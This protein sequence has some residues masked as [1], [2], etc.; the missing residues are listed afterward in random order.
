MPIIFAIIPTF[1]Y[2]F[3]CAFEGVSGFTCCLLGVSEGIFYGEKYQSI[4]NL[5]TG[6]ACLRISDEDLYPSKRRARRLTSYVLLEVCS[7][8]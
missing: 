2:L 8:L 5:R 7:Q 1:E 4:D 3:M 6:A